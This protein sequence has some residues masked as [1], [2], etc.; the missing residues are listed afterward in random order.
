VR[1]RPEK[2]LVVTLMQSNRRFVKNVQV[3][4]ECT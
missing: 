1:Q 2:S 3:R 4:Q